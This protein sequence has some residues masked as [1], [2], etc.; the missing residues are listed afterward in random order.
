MGLGGVVRGWEGRDRGVG[1]HVHL[2]IHSPTRVGGGT[3][4]DAGPPD[5]APV[6]AGLAHG[7]LID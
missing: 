2:F 1:M 4:A 7:A 6:G 3:V 5:V